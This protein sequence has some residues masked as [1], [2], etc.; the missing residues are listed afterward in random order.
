MAVIANTDSR[1]GNWLPGLLSLT[2][3]TLFALMSLAEWA[4]WGGLQA[5]LNRSHALLPALTEGVA[6]T[7]VN[8]TFGL[9]VAALTF[10]TRPDL[11]TWTVRIGVIATAS[12]L[13]AL[14]RAWVLE[15][16]TTTPS[17]ALYDQTEVVVGTAS[18]IVAV[19]SAYVAAS[20]IRHARSA[21]EQR[22]DEARRAAQ[23]VEDLQQEELRVRRMVSDQLHGGLQH[24]LVTVTASLDHLARATYASGNETLGNQISDL[25]ERLEEIREDDVRSLSQA[26]FPAGAELGTAQ[27]L[28]LMLRRLPPNITASVQI[29]PTFQDH[30][31]NDR[32]TTCDPRP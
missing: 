20:L 3:V 26:V 6:V 25:A 22:R 17:G 9:V 28:E 21:E 2:T 11:H 24:R 16:I 10:A 1:P 30:I 14:P 7:G 19:G 4:S 18:G 23:A 31:R 32:P 29:G 13:M 5:S 12:F 15:M 8:F 27:A